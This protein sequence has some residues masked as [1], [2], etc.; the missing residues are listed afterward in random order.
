MHDTSMKLMKESFVD[1]Y[2]DADKSYE[3]LD[4]GSYDVCGTYRKLFSN[5][6]N[7][8]GIDVSEGKG[9]DVV[10]KDPYSWDEINDSFYDIIISG[11]C[12]EHVEYPWLTMEQIA[13]KLKPDGIVAIIVPSSGD[14]H[15]FPIDTYRYNPDGMRALGKWAGL[16]VVSVER[17]DTHWA[18]VLAIYHLGPFD[19]FSAAGPSLLSTQPQINSTTALPVLGRS[20]TRTAI[21]QRER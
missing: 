17:I 11:Q 3:L 16:K 13:K 12:L 15:L 7:Y 14:I 19:R 10:L 20:G 4:V 9:V 8:T 1:R 18:D 2:I 6:V 5:N 21:G